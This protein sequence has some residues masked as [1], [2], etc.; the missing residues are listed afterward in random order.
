MKYLLALSIG[1]CAAFA[2]QADVPADY[3]S[4]CEGKTGK[5]LL[6]ALG[7]VVGPHTNVG[8]DGLWEVYRQSDM[9]ANGTLWDMYSTKEWPANFPKCGNYKLV[10]DCVNREHSF[11]KSWWGGGKQ[12]Q[13]ADAYHLYP[14][15]GKVNGQR[16]NFP[17]GE[18]AN[19][20]SLAANGSVR[21][22]GRLGKS[23]FPG[24]T[25]KVFEPDDM[26]KGDF[27]RTY[28]YMAA[29]YNDKIGG[30]NSDMLAGNNYPVYKEWAVNLLLKWSRQDPVSDKETDRNEA[31]SGFQHNRNPFIDHPELAEYI[32]G[33]KQGLAW[34]AGAEADPAILTPA[35]GSVI[36]LGL[37]SI[38]TSRHR[39]VT[40]K[41][42]ALTRDIEV[43]AWG[44][45]FSVTPS[46]LSAEQANAEGAVLTVTYLS[47]SAAT[48]AGTLFLRSGD[49]TSTC[50]LLCE[51]VDGL[52]VKDAV[53]VTESSFRIVWTCID[54]P[55]IRY[56]VDVRREGRSLEGY[57]KSVVAGDE[58]FTV[59]DLDPETDYTYT[60]S[61][62]SLTSRSVTV[63]T[64]APQPSVSFLYDG[65]LTFHALPGEP[66]EVAEILLYIENIP[67]NLTISV[68]A[69][70]EVSSDRSAWSQSAELVPGEDRFY[71]RLGGAAEGEYTTSVTARAG[72]YF[73]DDLD[74]TG[75]V[76]D[77]AVDFWEDFEA[78]TAAGGYTDKTVTGTACSWQ[79]NAIFESGTTNSYPNSGEMAARTPKSGGYL[80]MLESKAAGIG[81]MTVAARLW[82]SETAES[83]WDVLVS[84]DG[85]EN[86]EKAG[87]FSVTPNGSQT[88]YSEYVVSVKRSGNLRVKLSQTA[89]GRTM[90]DDIRLSSYVGNGVTEA[91]MTEYHTWDAFCRGS[92]LVLTNDGSMENRAAVYNYDGRTLYD[93]ILAA[94]ETELAL[95][96]GLYIVVVRDFSRRV[97]VK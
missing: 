29:A 93:G 77:S 35:D 58:S 49:A 19:G 1:T 84:A 28:F 57:P 53:D 63:R 54:D 94:G 87:S 80:T 73:N 17:F 48:G 79:T 86:W 30:W 88:E 85:G 64:L 41:G 5:A 15:D 90:I 68:T 2:L 83:V 16:S 4:T 50:T 45:G 78:V 9:R 75:I 12:I 61:S 39:E 38:G 62:P 34:Y 24:Y 69:P 23:T 37:S 60:V 46:T 47:A 10:G 31:V 36:D 96:Q 11:P 91:N 81:A 76:S 52:P 70:F 71:M 43:S 14:T 18:C 92:K 6:Q 3:Y 7:D 20:E 82:R 89:G 22:L 97:V 44:D 95:P 59:T 40:V 25:G 56:S 32:W 13:Y 26:Y 33:N 74:V 51:A 42:T 55:D 67:G 66:S 21:P 8:Y 72:D 27:A 65:E